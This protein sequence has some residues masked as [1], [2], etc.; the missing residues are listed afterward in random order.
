MP[1]NGDLPTVR[2][3]ITRYIK[4]QCSSS[5]E[6]FSTSL[7]FGSMDKLLAKLGIYSIR[8]TECVNSYDIHK[9]RSSKTVGQDSISHFHH[10]EVEIFENYPVHEIDFNLTQ[11]NSSLSLYKSNIFDNFNKIFS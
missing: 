1:D 9:E 11:I 10:F 3:V 8:I 5:L 6:S 7:L 2:R 4:F